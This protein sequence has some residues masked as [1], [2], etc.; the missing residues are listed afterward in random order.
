M[1]QIYNAIIHC[2]AATPRASK[3]VAFSRLAGCLPHYESED[4][5]P[6]EYFEPIITEVKD[7][8]KQAFRIRRRKAKDESEGKK[9]A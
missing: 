8:R 7:E 2:Y 3:A 5:K 4:E 6:F 9:R 1:T